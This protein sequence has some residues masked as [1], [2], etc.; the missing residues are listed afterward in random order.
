MRKTSREGRKTAFNVI[1]SRI[2]A[3]ISGIW[4]QWVQEFPNNWEIFVYLAEEHLT[5]NPMYLST[6][7]RWKE[8]TGLPFCYAFAGTVGM[9]KSFLWRFL[10]GASLKIRY[11]SIMVDVS[12]RFLYWVTVRS[13]QRR[14]GRQ[15]W[16][17]VQMST[18]F[19]C[20]CTDSGLKIRNSE[21]SDVTDSS[22][23]FQ[24]RVF[25]EPRGMVGGVKQ[26][27]CLGWYAWVNVLI[28]LGIKLRSLQ[29]S[30]GWSQ[31]FVFLFSLVSLLSP[32]HLVT[33]V[34]IFS[35]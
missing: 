18:A 35:L 13:L 3:C 8:A 34:K 10:G 22:N 21:C 23:E 5:S 31:E 4:I 6:W 2:I 20:L 1:T 30:C 7:F 33:P 28:Q 15:V 27:K 12:V 19:P 16:G 14:T 17:N 32:K 29:E 24:L 26:V 9:R 25:Q 11:F